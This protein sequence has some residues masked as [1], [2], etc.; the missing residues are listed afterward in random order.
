M[1]VFK[2]L[3]VSVIPILIAQCT[4]STSPA[5]NLTV[6]GI[7]GDNMVLQRDLKIAVWGTAEPGGRV[8]VSL[9]KTMVSGMVN[10]DSTW[11][12][13]LPKMVAGGPFVLTITS[14]TDTIILK[15]VMIGEVWLCCGQ[16][17]MNM[18][19]DQWGRVNNFETEIQN[20]NYPDIRLFQTDRVY[21]LTPQSSVGSTGWLEC[22]PKNISGFSATA[23]FFA[24]ELY[25]KLK[26]PIGL[27]HSSSGGTPVEA[28]TS[29]EYL[30]RFPEFT[31]VLDKLANRNPVMDDSVAQAFK[32]AMKDWRKIVK[33]NDRGLTEQFYRLPLKST[34]K[35]PHMNLPQLWEK[36]GLPNFDGSVW[37]RK[38]ITL[39]T[40]FTPGLWTLHLGPT[41]DVDAVWIN[42]KFIGENNSKNW[43]TIYPL[44]ENTLNIGINTIDV[45]ILDLGQKGGIWGL[46]EQLTLISE[47]G[48][49]ISLA[50]DWF[51]QVCT[52][53]KDF[54]KPP[55]DPQLKRRPT[56]LYNA[57]IHPLT[58]F[59]IKGV[60]WY[61]GESNATRAYQYRY[62]FP[63]L[64]ENW[65]K[66]WGQ[67]DFPFLYVQ[68]ANH[69]ERLD[70]PG[71]SRLAE[72]REA[73]AM[74]LTLPNTAMA[75]AI[76]NGDEEGID[77]HPKNKQE[78][79]RRLALL[80][81]DHV[82]GVDTVSS[83]PQFSKMEIRGNRVRVFFNSADGGLKTIDGNSVSGFALA[84]KD[85]KFVWAKATIEDDTIVLWNDE[86]VSPV[87]V[88]YAWADNPDCNLTNAY[89]LPA[90]PFRT[91]DWQGLTEGKK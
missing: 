88:R 41:D 59:T 86:I 46:P 42:G 74:A 50:G 60:I 15:N 29:R 82:Y 45:W 11:H 13:K 61:Q 57:M 83:G 27:V 4:L 53:L 58:P 21:A 76:D 75:I 67:G 70:Q 84:G 65:R 55:I 31:E 3:F 89:H 43:P 32:S 78:I 2:I 40:D 66:D 20:A 44:P 62:L 68:I 87:A 63:N 85:R 69:L 91:D 8:I 9:G 33:T 47:S 24:R 17:N 5:K 1:R 22:S 28:W 35:W 12:I 30:D 64:I 18:P 49:K 26:V 79:G 14:A 36:G 51:Y 7:F 71:E 6:T 34:E 19:L 72:L 38:V 25:R 10:K 56:V 81:M 48:K 54:P 23:Y 52:D 37:F 90:V 16:S 73:Q 39:P 80:A 77:I